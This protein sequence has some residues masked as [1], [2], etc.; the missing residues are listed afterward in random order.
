MKSD[1][2]QGI[3]V[4]ETQTPKTENPI[5]DFVRNTYSGLI[6]RV[7][8]Q[9]KTSKASVTR[10]LNRNHDLEDLISRFRDRS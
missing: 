6:K 5:K 7:L 2:L 3:I 1:R 10:D 9:N 4:P 8:H